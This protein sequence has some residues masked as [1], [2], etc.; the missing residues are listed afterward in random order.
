MKLPFHLYGHAQTLP[1]GYRNSQ[2]HSNR[3]RGSRAYKEQPFKAKDAW[4]RSLC[5]SR[6]L[7]CCGNAKLE[8]ICSFSFFVS[9]NIKTYVRICAYIQYVT[10]NLIEIF[11]LT[12]YSLKHTQNTKLHFNC[13]PFNTSQFSET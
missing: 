4:V 6:E 10:L 11:K 7:P 1:P 8:D 12:F 5:N 3:L 13:Q 9:K 2:E